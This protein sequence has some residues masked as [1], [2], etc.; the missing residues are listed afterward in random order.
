ME[1]LG[2]TL[3]SLWLMVFG[4]LLYSKWSE[5]ISL[6]LNEWGDFLAGMTAPIAFIWLIVGY[7]LQR[8]ELNQNTAALKEQSE[9]LKLH[10]KYLKATANAAQEQARIASSSHFRDV[11]CDLGRK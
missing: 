1:K 7:F 6:S 11:L 9:E 10:A 5:A 3:T 8:K 2:I 4:I